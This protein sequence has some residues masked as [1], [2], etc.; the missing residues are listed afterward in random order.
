[1]PSN[2]IVSTNIPSKVPTTDNE[3]YPVQQLYHT[4]S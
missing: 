4:I 2:G 1:M 3:E